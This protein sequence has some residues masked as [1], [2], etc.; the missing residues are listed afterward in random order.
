MVGDVLTPE[1]SSSIFHFC[2]GRQRERYLSINKRPSSYSFVTLCIQFTAYSHTS[3]F[4]QNRTTKMCFFICFVFTN[5]WSK[6]RS[7]G[8]LKLYSFQ[9]GCKVVRRVHFHSP[10]IPYILAHA[11]QLITTIYYCSTF[12]VLV[13]FPSIALFP[14]VCLH[15]CCLMRIF[16]M[17][18]DKVR[19]SRNT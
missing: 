13:C 16:F 14:A 11:H 12:F 8:V 18:N 9:V 17:F 3:I 10:F 2:C 6:L 4:C 7:T 5:C 15:A 19:T 1:N